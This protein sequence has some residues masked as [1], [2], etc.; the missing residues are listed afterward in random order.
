VHNSPPSPRHPRARADLT[1][2]PEAGQ[3]ALRDPQGTTAR[4]LTL[5]GALVWTCCDGRHD[6]EAIAQRVSLALPEAGDPAAVQAS[7]NRLLAQLSQ[8]GMLA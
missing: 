7:V 2:R 1:F 6:A 5:V 3:F 8:D 4:C